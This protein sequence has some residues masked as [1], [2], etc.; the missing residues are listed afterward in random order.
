LKF[1]GNSRHPLETCAFRPRVTRYFILD[2]FMIATGTIITSLASDY[3]LNRLSHLANVNNDLKLMCFLYNYH[4]LSKR[5]MTDER[6]VILRKAYFIQQHYLRGFWRVYSN[7]VSHYRLFHEKLQREFRWKNTD[8]K[9][10]RVIICYSD[11]IGADT[12]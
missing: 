5:W 2:Y 3:Y 11:I 4:S 1:C 10:W 6:N 9:I 7:R 12:V 8:V